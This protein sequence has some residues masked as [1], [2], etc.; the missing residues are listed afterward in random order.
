MNFTLFNTRSRL[1]NDVVFVDG[2]WGSG[3]SLLAPIIASMEGVEKAQIIEQFDYPLHLYALNRIGFE[4][5]KAMTSFGIDLI[6]YN[7]AIGRSINLR[8]HDWSGLNLNTAGL[9]YVKRLFSQEGDSVMANSSRHPALL[10]MPHYLFPALDV[11]KSILDERLKYILV[12]RDPLLVFTHWHSYLQRFLSPREFTLSV[13]SKGVKVPW[14][15]AENLPSDI[16]QPAS[17][18]QTVAF[19][20]AAYEKLLTLLTRYNDSDPLQSSSRMLVF[21]FDQICY[22]TS[23]VLDLLSSYLGRPYLKSLQQVLNREK[24]PRTTQSE[25]RGFISYGFKPDFSISD[26]DQ[27]NE[28]LSL[29]ESS[30]DAALHHRFLRICSEYEQLAKQLQHSC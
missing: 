3:K 4:E 24:L 2:L 17:V 22:E 21:T 9:R 25:G 10:L 18:V 26:A 8:W 11:L 6:S 13:S 23:S 12:L 7:T 20:T 1:N 16:G 29:I 19:L 15:C 30:A 14:F 28:V 27:K 5:A